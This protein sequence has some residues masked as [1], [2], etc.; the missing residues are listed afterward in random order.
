M[1]IFLFIW[2]L[3]NIFFSI[4][5]FQSFEYDLPEYVYVYVSS[6]FFILGILWTSWICRIFFTILNFEKPIGYCFLKFS[7]CLILCSCSAF[8]ITWLTCLILY[9]SYWI[10]SSSL[11]LFVSLFNQIIQPSTH[12]KNSLSL[13]LL[14]YF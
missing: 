1:C 14:F 2:L 5:D 13:T 8:P 3:S 11:F 10:F 9:H 6:L 4:S 7:F 12:W